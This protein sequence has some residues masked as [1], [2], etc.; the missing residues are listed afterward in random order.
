MFNETEKKQRIMLESD[1]K[2]EKKTNERAKNEWDVICSGSNSSISYTTYN[3]LKRTDKTSN[4]DN[5][6]SENKT[7][8][9]KQ[10]I[11]YAY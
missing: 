8:R 6:R 10:T 5:T 11:L 3:R 2:E 1:M 9:A 4:N 7:I